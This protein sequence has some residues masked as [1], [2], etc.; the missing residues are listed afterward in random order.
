MS[1]GLPKTCWII[2]DG[3]AG[4]QNACVGLAHQLHMSP[5]IKPLIH[6]TINTYLPEFLGRFLPPRYLVKALGNLTEPWP[7]FLITSGRASVA[8]SVAIKKLSK[9]KTFTLHLQNPRICPS[10]FDVIIAPRHDRLEGPHILSLTGSP[11]KVDLALC[12][13]A[14]IRFLKNPPAP[15]PTFNDKTIVAVLI[16]GPNSL[17]D[18]D[19]T[20]ASSLVTSLRRL[21][22]NRPDLYFLITVSR[23]TREGVFSYLQEACHSLPAFIWDN[24]GENPYMAFLGLAQMI[25]VTSDSVAMVSE[26]CATGKP[27]YVVSLP[28]KRKKTSKFDSF[29]QWLVEA[30]HT[31]SFSVPLETYHPIP[32]NEANKLHTFVLTHYKKWKVKNTQRIK[33][34]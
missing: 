10:H 24:T 4:T 18:F 14:R 8:L 25:C 29:H 32:L 15:L 21:L 1:L 19:Q 33:K 31:R 17:Y 2:T 12:K 30:N 13:A 5:S 7:H 28:K 34:G 9:G 27:V 20:E 26:A 23:R 22:V 3:K 6:K 11:H 16:G